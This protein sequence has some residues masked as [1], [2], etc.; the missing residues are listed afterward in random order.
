MKTPKS[1]IRSAPRAVDPEPHE[2]EDIGELEI[3]ETEKQLAARAPRRLSD[4]SAYG[5]ELVL[6]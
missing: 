4:V 6:V 5:T 1:S 2:D 3:T